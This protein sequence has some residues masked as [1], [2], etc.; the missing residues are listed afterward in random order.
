MKVTD[1]MIEAFLF[2]E[3]AKRE[4]VAA[5]AENSQT[6]IAV[7]DIREREGYERF[8]QAT[9]HEGVHLSLIKDAIRDAL[10]DLGAAAFREA[11]L[12]ARGAEVMSG[13]TM[14]EATGVVTFLGRDLDGGTPW[15][16]G[17]DLNVPLA[18]DTGQEVRLTW[19]GPAQEP[20]TEEDR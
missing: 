10:I 4:L 20:D 16:V 9:R 18:P 12:S 1:D 5:R 14:H 13:A 3:E 11:R 8:W 7:A 17:V 15:H 6:R 19:V 2:W